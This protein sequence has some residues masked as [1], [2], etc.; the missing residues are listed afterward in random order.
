MLEYVPLIG[1]LV[2]IAIAYNNH[3]QQHK[4][5]QQQSKELEELRHNRKRDLILKYYPPLAESLRDSIPDIAYTYRTGHQK[6]YGDYLDALIE[7][8]NQSTLNIIESLD[9]PRAH[10]VLLNNSTFIIQ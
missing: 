1:L 5:I 10:S 3:R 6:E 4:V 7:M 2:T 8:A 9:E